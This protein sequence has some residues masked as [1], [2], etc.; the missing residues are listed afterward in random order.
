MSGYS[1]LDRV[2]T[3][4]ARCGVGGGHVRGGVS[5]SI[6]E[7]EQ[8]RYIERAVAPSDCPWSCWRV[9]MVLLYQCVKSLSI[10]S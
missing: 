1:G 8:R 2:R 10:S 6:S 3:N 7:N 4:G 5:A 9:V